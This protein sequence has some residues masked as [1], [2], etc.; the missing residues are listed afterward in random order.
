MKEWY[1]IGSPSL[2]SGLENN[3]FNDYKSD[4]FAEMISSEVGE[5]VVFYNNDIS[6]E[7][8]SRAIIQNK[9]AD[10]DTNSIK[11]QVLANIGTLNLFHYVKDKSGAIWL[12]KGKVDNNGIYDKSA[13]SICNYKLHWQNESGEIVSRYAHILNA[14][15][16]NNGEKENKTL[17]L[18]S[19]QFM[20]YL[21]Y[22]NE[23]ML[24]DDNKRIH[25]SK[26]IRKCKPYEITRIDDISYDF[27]DKGLIN[28]IFTQVQA[29]PT[30]DKLVDNGAGDKVWICDYKEPTTPSSPTDPGNDNGN[31]SPIFLQIVIKWKGDK[32]INAGGTAKTFTA[33]FTDSD[34]N[35]VTDPDFEWKVS[36]TDEFSSLLNIETLSDKRCKVKLGYDDLILGNYVKISVVINGKEVTSE[37]I[38]IGGNL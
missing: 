4:S 3:V 5:D 8:A 18:Q 15:A 16:Y 32:V 22:D 14:S 28:L 37:L 24:L 12:L 9:M 6:T 13:A 17:T 36:I 21:P 30:N 38:E 7:F 25:M 26:N 1:L 35:S 33:T 29:S 20:V 31:Q 11:R 23:T 27:T 34:G 2:S 19:N 10:S